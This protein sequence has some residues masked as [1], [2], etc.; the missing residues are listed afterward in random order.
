M[1]HPLLTDLLVPPLSVT[2]KAP[3]V[4]HGGADALDGHLDHM[5]G[6]SR[7]TTIR[8]PDTGLVFINAKTHQ[9]L[10]P[11]SAMASASKAIVQDLS[12]SNPNRVD[13]LYIVM[14]YQ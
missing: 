7:S 2:P 6:S 3:Y 1:S 14:T 11:L 13:Y 9:S 5:T 8:V 12:E 4:D 10:K